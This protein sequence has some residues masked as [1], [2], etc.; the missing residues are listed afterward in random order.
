MFACVVTFESGMA[1]ASTLLFDRGLPTINLN[2]AAGSNRSNVAWADQEQTNPPAEYWL[3]GDT[4]SLSGSGMYHIDTIRIWIVSN[5]EDT[6]GLGLSYG[7]SYDNRVKS[8][9]YTATQVKYVNGEDYQGSSGAYRN[10]FQIDFSFDAY[11]L[12]GETNSFYLGGPWTPYSAGGYVNP[13]LHASNSDLSGSSQEGAD[14]V[15]RWFHINANGPVGSEPWDS[16]QSGWDKKSDANIQIFGSPVP[17]PTT[18]ILLGFGL[19]GM[20][21]V[22]RRKN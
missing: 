21:G 12:A 14:G 13:F 4:F 10:I 22:S 8:T 9:T 3:P 2:N 18:L 5:S 16:S 17:E 20:A 19:L 11:T 15:F 7:R 6:S 1:S